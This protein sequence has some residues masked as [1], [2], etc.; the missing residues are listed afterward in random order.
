MEAA[1]MAGVDATG[2]CLG[3]VLDLSA[4]SSLFGGVRVK[5][6]R[7]KE[8][9]DGPRFQGLLFGWGRVRTTEG[10]VLQW[11]HAFSRMYDH[12]LTDSR[13]EEL[14]RLRPAFLRFGRTE[15]RVI[16]SASGWARSDLAELLLLTWF[17][18]AHAEA[19]GRR[20]FKR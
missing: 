16:L 7:S 4:E 5:S 12:L 17:L 9:Q 18:R 3:R 1:L 14:L 6:H 20:I 10:E 13:G 8:G 15:T 11:R 19:R 2:E